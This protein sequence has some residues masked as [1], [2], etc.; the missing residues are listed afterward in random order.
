MPSARRCASPRRRV[1][2]LK[3]ATITSVRFSAPTGIAVREET[4]LRARW[5][6]VSRVKRY[7]LTSLFNCQRGEIDSSSSSSSNHGDGEDDDGGGI[8]D[9]EHGSVLRSCL[10]VTQLVTR[11]RSFTTRAFSETRIANVNG[12]PRPASGSYKCKRRVATVPADGQR[13]DLRASSSF[14]P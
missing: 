3:C 9:G 14:T 13:C 2:C 6:F 11:R 1:S 7:G 4:E 10:L 5:L 12:D 8:G